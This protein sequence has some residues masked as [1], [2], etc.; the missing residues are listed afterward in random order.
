LRAIDH[1]PQRVGGQCRRST[2]RGGYAHARRSNL[3]V[4]E[5]KKGGHRPALPSPLKKELRVLHR[6]DR[7]K[8]ELLEIPDTL[9]CNLEGYDP[10][11]ARDLDWP[12]LVLPGLYEKLVK[13]VG[14]RCFHPCV[15]VDGV[16]AV[17]RLF[18]QLLAE[19]RQIGS[20]LLQLLDRQEG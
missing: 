9:R 18:D 13:E 5:K 15:S 19:R 16:E 4:E 20:T 14:G 8:D 7:G 3:H 6:D 17:R 12:W 2:L 10:T 1:V 11:L